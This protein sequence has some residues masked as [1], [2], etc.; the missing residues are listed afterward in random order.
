[1]GNT[2]TRIFVLSKMGILVDGIIAAI[3]STE[4]YEIVSCTEPG[5]QCWEKFVASKAELALIHVSALKFY[6]VDIIPKLREESPALRILLFGPPIE[7]E[8]MLPLVRAGVNGY[9]AD[10]TSAEELL[11]AVAGVQHDQLWLDRALLS[12]LAK[13]AM[14]MEIVIEDTI[15]ERMEDLNGELSPRELE[16]M[17]WVMQGFATR[18]IAQRIH[19]SEQSV[20]LHLGRMFKKFD[21][22]NRSQLILSMFARVCP[23]S[24]MV[25]LIRMSVDRRRIAKGRPPLIRDPLGAHPGRHV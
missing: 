8:R 19:L 15:Y 5:N 24:H 3:Q 25:S 23:M 18:D 9:V 13:T 7:R 21:V 2:T 11:K 14:D 22:S 1:M 4:R 16:V 17:H 12:E 6:P 10:T 20:K